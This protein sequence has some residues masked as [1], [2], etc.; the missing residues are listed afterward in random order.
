MRVTLSNI[1]NSALRDPHTTLLPEQE[2]AF[3]ARVEL[4]NG[5]KYD[6]FHERMAEQGFSQ[7]IKDMAGGTKQLPHATYFISGL[8]EK[9]SPE[10]V[11]NRARKA[12][13]KHKK[14]SD[15]MNIKEHI[16]VVKASD[17]WFELE[18]YEEKED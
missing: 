2:T 13:E 16:I 7:T 12:V 10:A 3:L 4:S 5:S 14:L 17:V 8:T 18:D 6:Y 15:Q 11:F 1:V 9:T